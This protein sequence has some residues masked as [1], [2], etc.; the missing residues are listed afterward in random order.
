MGARF[1]LGLGLLVVVVTVLVGG[2]LGVLAASFEGLVDQVISRTMDILLC[3]AKYFIGNC[4]D[5][6]FRTELSQYR[7]IH[8]HCGDL[9]ANVVRLV[10]SGV[11]IEKKKNLYDGKSC[12]A[13]WFRICQQIYCNCMAPLI[14]KSHI[15]V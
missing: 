8:C 10:R 11:L 6:H 3:L 7:D 14:A 1:G 13:S 9:L 12:G 2:V 15:W 5:G 4:C